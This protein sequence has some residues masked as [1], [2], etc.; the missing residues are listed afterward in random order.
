M[1]VQKVGDNFPKNNGQKTDAQN[2]RNDLEHGFGDRDW[3][4]AD[5]LLG[6]GDAHHRLIVGSVL[7]ILEANLTAVLVN[8]ITKIAHN[9]ICLVIFAVE[10]FYITDS[11][12]VVIHIS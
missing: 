11:N 3:Q 1:L 2:C 10:S 8:A 4:T 12:R 7:K 9:F 6:Y 5:L